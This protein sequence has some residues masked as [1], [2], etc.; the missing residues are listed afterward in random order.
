M[1]GSVLR[2][3]SRLLVA[4][5][6]VAVLAGCGSGSSVDSVAEPSGATSSTATSTTAVPAACPAPTVDPLVTKE[7][8][9][10]LTATRLPVR[11]CL[12]SVDVVERSNRPDELMFLVTLRVPT[13]AAP[14][15]LR[16][17]ATD[18]AHLWKESE[19]GQRT[20]VLAVTNWGYAGA[21]YL[22]YLIDEDFRNHPWDGTPTHEAELAIWTV[23]SKG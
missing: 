21:K 11:A 3:G 9:T 18:I 5:A 23:T 22:D 15:D 4:V 2:V 10:A 6:G 8:K 14:D 20:D 7:L 16:P 17:I 12:T 13:A 19:L 1:V